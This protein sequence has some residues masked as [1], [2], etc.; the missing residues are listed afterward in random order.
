MNIGL[1][2]QNSSKDAKHCHVRKQKHWSS[3]KNRLDAI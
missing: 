1:Q 2:I 3:A